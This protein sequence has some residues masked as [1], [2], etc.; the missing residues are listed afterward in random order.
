MKM[1]DSSVC[2]AK[3]LPPA[4]KKRKRI[5]F[6][7]GSILKRETVS[8]VSARSHNGKGEI[9]W[10]YSINDFDYSSF[11]LNY[12]GRFGLWIHYKDLRHWSR[13]FIMVTGH[14]EQK[15]TVAWMIYCF[16]KWNQTFPRWTFVTESMSWPLNLCQTKVVTKK[17]HQQ[18][19]LS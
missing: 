3:M 5:N 12:C 4:K 17:N 9:L 11:T 7:K 6:N 8:I 2:G 14:Q 15:E 18:I 10:A 1:I 13:D 19:Q 16:A